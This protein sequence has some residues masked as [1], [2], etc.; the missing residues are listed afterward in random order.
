MNLIY[1]KEHE[2]LVRFALLGVAAV[3]AALTL[4]KVATY[5]TDSAKAQSIVKKAVDRDKP[6]KELLEKKLADFKEVADVLKKK[7]LFVPPPPKRHPVTAV[8]GIL[9]SE[10]LING[11]WYKAGAKIGDAKLL[12]VEP[13]RVKIEWNGQEKYF[14]PL[15]AAGG[16]SSGERGRP[17]MRRSGG[18][19][20]GPPMPEGGPRG[21]GDFGNLSPEQ[22]AK[23]M[24][25]MMR[26]RRERF[27]SMSPEERERFRDEMRSR[28]G[29]RGP[30]GP[31][32]GFGGRG[33]PGGGRG[34]G[35]SR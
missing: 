25:E 13:T 27:E 2:R 29:G 11:R 24:E 17:E 33:G 28:F 12:V 5:F 15:A 16:G 35:R 26:A 23:M 22:R 8:L 21:P 14:A 1:L 3:T 31:G 32:G 20:G 34:P 18:S 9:G 10:A 4:V 30:G 6:D 19:R 7:N